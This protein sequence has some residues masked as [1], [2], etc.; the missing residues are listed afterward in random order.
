MQ[1]THAART[2]RALPHLRRLDISLETCDKRDGAL[3]QRL[4]MAAV[5]ALA[6]CESLEFLDL[7][8]LGGFGLEAHA[9]ELG[10]SMQS[11]TALTCL[12]MADHF[13]SAALLNND[14]FNQMPGFED[15]WKKMKPDT[16]AGFMGVISGDMG[17]VTKNAMKNQVQCPARCSHCFKRRSIL[18]LTT[19]ASHGSRAKLAPQ[20]HLAIVH[21]ATLAKL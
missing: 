10:K 7:S 19:A 16:Y 2:L 1:A 18:R 5:P 9:R 12:N 4:R 21:T 3:R 15:R 14:V 17:E 11:L 20:L 8:F 13:T 6:G